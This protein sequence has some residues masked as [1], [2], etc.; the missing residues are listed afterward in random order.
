MGRYYNK[1]KETTSTKYLNRYVPPSLTPK[2]KEETAKILLER[3]KSVKRRSNKRSNKTKSYNRKTPSYNK[4]T[5]TY[6]RKPRRSSWTVQFNNK[7]GGLKSKKIEDLAKYFKVRKSILDDIYNKG[8][9]AWNTSGSRLGVGR[10]AWAYARLYK[11]IL[12]II[13]AR[14][15]GALPSS[16]GHDRSQV[17]KAVKQ[18][19]YIA[20]LIPPPAKKFSPKSKR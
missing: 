19:K 8:A 2:Q 18:N 16:E 12:N 20:P 3:R 6:G 1:L 9:K 10:N 4:K 15:G 7:Y 5:P 17:E 14:K 13:K 11:G